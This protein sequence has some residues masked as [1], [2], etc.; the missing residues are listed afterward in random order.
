M[1]FEDISIYR[2]VLPDKYNPEVW[3]IDLSE[4]EY[5]DLIYEG[6]R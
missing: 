6:D 4:D 5:I 3:E 1:A 2:Y